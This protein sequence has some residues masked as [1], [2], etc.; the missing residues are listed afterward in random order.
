MINIHFGWALF[1]VKARRV[2]GYKSRDYSM[3]RAIQEKSMIYDLVE[4]LAP[5]GIIAQPGGTL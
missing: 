4:A 1:A 5:N 2:G 3:V